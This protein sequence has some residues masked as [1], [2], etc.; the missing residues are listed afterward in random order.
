MKINILF[1]DENII[2]CE[3]PPFVS[4]QKSDKDNM[5]TLL[6]NAL[7]LIEEPYVV[8]R[9]DT[10][11]SGLMVYAKNKKTAA[12][13]SEQIAKNE[14]KKTYLCIVHSKPE[15]KSGTFEDLLFKDS[16][17]NKSF[18]VKRERKGV[19]KAVLNYELI[20]TKTVND[21][22]LSLVKVNLVTGRTHQIRVQFSSRKM[23]L[24]GDGK[25]GA[26]DNSN[27]ALFSS[28]LSFKYK[29]ENLTFSLLPRGLVW[30]NFIQE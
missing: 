23:P 11:V 22:I 8:H 5:V 26:S 14:F 19:K 20:D 25:Y 3:K 30:D 7:S 16:K 21:K 28:E 18:V 12:D 13:L 27:I 29:N 4:S 9:L 6:Q 1:E 2:V 10:A 24:Y 17:K 15:N